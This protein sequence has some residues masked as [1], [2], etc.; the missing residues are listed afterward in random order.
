MLK[1]FK[2]EKLRCLGG[3]FEEIKSICFEKMPHIQTEIDKKSQI[4]QI[5]EI[6]THFLSIFERPGLSKMFTKEQIRCPAG[7]CLEIN[8][9]FQ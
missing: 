2:K 7:F 4:I 1:T 5:F 8:T 6:F 9:I 3:F